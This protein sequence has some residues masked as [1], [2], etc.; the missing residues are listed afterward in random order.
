MT[1]KTD[2]IAVLEDENAELRS[3]QKVLI[4]KIKAI[5]SAWYDEDDVDLE[6]SIEDAVKYVADY[7]Q[8][9]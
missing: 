5:Y 8:W 1:T 4:K 7:E 6:V 2:R 3:E 9:M